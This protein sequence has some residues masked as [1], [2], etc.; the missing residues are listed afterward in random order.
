MVPVH[1]AGPVRDLLVTAVW[2]LAKT[3]GGTVHTDLRQLIEQL[4]QLDQRRDQPQARPCFA[5]ETAAARSPTVEVT[6]DAMAQVMGCSRQYVRRL[7]AAGVLPARRLGRIWL[8]A[9]EEERTHADS[10]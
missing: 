2:D 5:K 6:V 4:H 10:D 9:I 1:L 7:A 8:I 3:N